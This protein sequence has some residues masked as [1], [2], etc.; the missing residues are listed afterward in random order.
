[1]NKA[2]GSSLLRRLGRSPSA[3]AGLFIITTYA[4]VALFSTWLTPYSPVAQNPADRL[5]APNGQYWVGTDEFGR[6]IF[7]RL[8]VGA[9]NSLTVAM[10]SVSLAFVGGTLLGTVSGYAGGWTDNVIM[11]LVDLMFAFPALL[12]ALAIAAALGPGLR[13]TVIAIAVVYLPIFAR[14]ARGSV[15]LLKGLEFVEAS[16]SLGVGHA[17]LIFKHILPNA[18]APS[19]V[20]LSLAFSW[21]ILTEAALSFLGL[22]TIPPNP[23]WGSM[24]SDARKM[25]ELAPWMAVAPGLAIMFCVLGFNLLGDGVRDILDPHLHLTKKIT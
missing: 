18:I 7:S 15:L 14:V 5:L 9:T 13:N 16:R 21:A 22:G 1:M 11:R 19:L 20:Q 2:A 24:L 6:D 25:M 17:R 12:L 23:S 4:V 8:M 3:M 10:L